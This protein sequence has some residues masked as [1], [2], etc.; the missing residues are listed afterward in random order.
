MSVK[1]IKTRTL[2]NFS[3]GNQEKDRNF[4]VAHCLAAAD[5]ESHAAPACHATQAQRIAMDSIIKL[6]IDLSAPP[7]GPGRPG[8]A[9]KFQALRLRL[10]ESSQLLV[11]FQI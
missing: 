4:L 2:L 3:L 7:L 8:A 11:Q 9:V 5:F 1:P 6:E 10:A